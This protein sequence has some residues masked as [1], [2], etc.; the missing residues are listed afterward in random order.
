MS[1]DGFIQLGN[2][3]HHVRINDD[4]VEM[5]SSGV[6]MLDDFL[7]LRD[8]CQRVRQQHGV[9]FVLYDSRSGKGVDREVR[10]HMMKPVPDD[11]RP[12][13][14]ASFGAKF[15]TRV[16]VNMLDRALVAFGKG[17][18]GVAMFEIES[19]ARAY[20]ERERERHRLQKR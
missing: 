19:D 11:V 15:S 5:R 18:S 4:L 12:T 16:F 1:D 17:P 8:I 7:A 3:P 9:L 14:A 13:A 6:T 20:L 2:G 10:K